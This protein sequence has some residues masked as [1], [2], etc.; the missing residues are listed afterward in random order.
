MFY[1]PEFLVY[2]IPGIITEDE[3]FKYIVRVSK[4]WNFEEEI[5]KNLSFHIPLGIQNLIFMDD[6][7][8]TCGIN[9]PVK[10]LVLDGNAVIKVLH[11]NEYDNFL[12]KK[13]TITQL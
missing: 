13:Y 7:S 9:K 8:E 11:V 10:K 1:L 12:Y 5:N 3:R 6:E 2:D 4:N